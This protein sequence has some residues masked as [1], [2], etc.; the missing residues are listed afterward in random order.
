[1][2]KLGEKL[3]QDK[4]RLRELALYYLILADNNQQ[5]Y[6]ERIQTKAIVAYSIFVMSWIY[7]P[8]L[9][10][11]EAPRSTLVIAGVGTVLFLVL[12]FFEQLDY[13]KTLAERLVG[14][15]TAKIEKTATTESNGHKPEEEKSCILFIL[16]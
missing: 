1:V 16:M 10:R 14:T 13:L 9:I 4:P 7:V 5:V 3:G 8:Y 6:F 12:G 2:E 11:A 15:Q